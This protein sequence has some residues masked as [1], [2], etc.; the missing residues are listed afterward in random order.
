MTAT[1]RARKPYTA[2]QAVKHARCADH[3]AHAYT[4]TGFLCVAKMPTAEETAARA[5]DMVTFADHL[6]AVRAAHRPT[7]GPSIDYGAS[8]VGRNVLDGY[9]LRRRLAAELGLA[10]ADPEETA[11]EPVILA[12]DAPRP[13][14]PFLAECQWSGGRHDRPD[15]KDGPRGAILSCPRPPTGEPAPFLVCDHASADD[16]PCVLGRYHSGAHVAADSVRTVRAIVDPAE[17]THDRLVAR[18]TARKASAAERR[19]AERDR[20]AAAIGAP[21]PESALDDAAASAAD[22]PPTFAPDPYAAERA[23]APTAPDDLAAA[24]AAVDPDTAAAIL[25]GA[26]PP[27]CERPRGAPECGPG[28]GWPHGT[29]DVWPVSYAPTAPEP[30]PEPPSGAPAPERGASA[31]TCERCGQTF[32]RGGSGAEWHRVNRPDCAASRRASSAA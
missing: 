15:A 13:Y 31:P 1:A 8:H 30:A 23:P 11:P 24:L 7:L 12:D 32:R 3:V 26:A 14:G 16:M 6:A 9:T 29:H 27:L 22:A 17:H 18:E 10:G 20:L 5:V 25:D 21:E 4:S 2:A 28:I 19:A